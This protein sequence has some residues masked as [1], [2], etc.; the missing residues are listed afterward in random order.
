MTGESRSGL[1]SALG[2]ACHRKDRSTIGPGANLRAREEEK[3]PRPKNMPRRLPANGPCRFEL[4]MSRMNG[5]GT[6]RRF[7]AQAAYAAGRPNVPLPKKVF[8]R[9]AKST[10]RHGSAIRIESRGVGGNMTS[11][12]K[13]AFGG[14]KTGTK[15]CED[16]CKFYWRLCGATSNKGRPAMRRLKKKY[17]KQNRELRAPGLEHENE[18]A[19]NSETRCG[20]IKGTTIKQTR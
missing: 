8:G 11:R 17:Q 12:N 13:D 14:Q 1:V 9:G 5:D 18:M 15:G 6:F 10:S 16:Q 7:I 3:H 20:R 19:T 4:V 2:S